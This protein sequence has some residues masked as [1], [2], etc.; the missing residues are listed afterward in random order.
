MSQ[1]M[2][3]K[4]VEHKFLVDED[5][6]QAGFR[7]RVLGLGPERTSR[8]EVADTYYVPRH[9]PGV[10][11]RH[12]FDAELQDL[13]LKSRDGGDTESRTE[14]TLKLEQ[15]AGDQQ[16]GVRALL[17]ALLGADGVLWQGALHKRLQAFYFP[18]CE[19]VY[20]EA[21]TDRTGEPRGADAV[22]R[23]VEFEARG[24]RDLDEALRIL[25]RYE[26]RTGF[27]GRPRSKR[28]LFDLLLAPQMATATATA[29]ATGGNPGKGAAG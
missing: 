14:V 10:I 24:A 20:Y 27:A 6:D 22:V 11:L 2:R 13:T 23:C 17:D 3:F 8:V 25:E 1:P 12:R 19:I 28:S 5:F 15:A 26:Q 29:T 16:A 21:R 18:D 4:E 9:R 7:E